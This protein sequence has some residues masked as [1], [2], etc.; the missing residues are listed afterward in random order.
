VDVGGGVER[1]RALPQLRTLGGVWVLQTWL[2]EGERRGS[3]ETMS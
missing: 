2:F 1:R 3:A